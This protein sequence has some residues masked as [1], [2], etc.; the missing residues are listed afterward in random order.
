MSSWLEFINKR[1]I[2]IGYHHHL[3]S[4]SRMFKVLHEETFLEVEHKKS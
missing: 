1:I 4:L 3:Y 2:M